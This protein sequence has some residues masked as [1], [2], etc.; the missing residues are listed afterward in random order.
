MALKE[1]GGRARREVMLGLPHYYWCFPLRDKGKSLLGE[2]AWGRT[3]GFE[4]ARRDS[5][6]GG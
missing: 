2:G 3:V 1:A 4:W 5:S 6:G